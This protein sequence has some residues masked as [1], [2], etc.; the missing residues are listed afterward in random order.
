[1]SGAPVEWSETTRDVVV[2]IA[3]SAYAYGMTDLESMKIY[4]TNWYRKHT[5]VPSQLG[6][7]IGLAWSVSVAAAIVGTFFV[8]RVCM[9]DP[10]RESY[11]ITTWL[12][13]A[14]FFVS[15]G[16][17]QRWTWFFSGGD[18][19]SLLIGEMKSIN[20]GARNEPKTTTNW[21]SE[22]HV[23]KSKRSRI[24]SRP[25]DPKLASLVALIVALAAA[26]AATYLIIVTVQCSNRDTCDDLE[27]KQLVTATVLWSA[28]A[29]WA[30]FGLFSSFTFMYST[31]RM[32]QSP[33]LE[34][35]DNMQQQQQGETGNPT[36]PLENAF[37]M[38]RMSRRTMKSH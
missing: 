2:L 6:S 25:P 17:T 4:R 26:A 28:F 10:R 19:S 36:I 13:A 22:Q 35:L 27:R 23:L 20:E 32:S 38:P 18:A 37:L 33:L 34:A 7:L 8:I 31:I 12:V 9:L 5:N 14:A 15:V 3:L 30:V 24:A 29:G 16:L 21:T 11:I 1:M